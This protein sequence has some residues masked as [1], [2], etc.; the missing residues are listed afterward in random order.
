VLVRFSE[1]FRTAAAS[2]GGR[3]GAD[4]TTILRLLHGYESPEQRAMVRDAVAKITATAR[5][6]V[7]NLYRAKLDLYRV[8]GTKPL[9]Y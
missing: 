5:A 9:V 2:K 1:R 7:T 4:E 3:G 6:T 8:L